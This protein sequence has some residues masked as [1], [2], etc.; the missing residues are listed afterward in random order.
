MHSCGIS[1]V[2]GIFWLRSNAQALVLWIWHRVFREIFQDGIENARHLSEVGA[3]FGF[4]ATGDC[5][6][7]FV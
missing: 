4:L 5:S 3:S 1:R 6:A 7:F 2:P